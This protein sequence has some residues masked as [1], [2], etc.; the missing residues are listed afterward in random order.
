MLCA[1]S[2]P[3]QPP[4]LAV[5][6]FTNGSPLR[7]DRLPARSREAGDT[8]RYE[9][10]EENHLGSD[11]KAKASSV[12]L[13]AEEE[14]ELRSSEEPLKYT[15][16][17]VVH[18]IDGAV[19]DGQLKDEQPA[20]APGA[21][22]AAKTAVKETGT[23]S[24]QHTNEHMLELQTTMEGWTNSYIAWKKLVSRHG[25]KPRDSENELKDK[26]ATKMLEDA[27]GCIQEFCDE[28]FKNTDEGKRLGNLAEKEAKAG[29]KEASDKKHFA[30]IKAQQVSE[31]KERKVNGR[32]LNFTDGSRGKEMTQKEGLLQSRGLEFVQT[33]EE[34]ILGVHRAMAMTTTGQLIQEPK[35]SD[36][37]LTMGGGKEG[38]ADKKCRKA[39]EKETNWKILAREGKELR[40]KVNLRVTYWAVLPSNIF[41][42]PLTKHP[43]RSRHCKFRLM[44]VLN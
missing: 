32:H 39:Q 43:S 12:P 41:R 23:A 11:N 14:V 21:T 24:G 27:M 17:N 16:E 31:E 7:P 33:H 38:Y 15:I 26:A 34:A 36:K 35:G 19:Q 30:H 9:I 42:I 4:T 44:L 13:I 40:M 6:H 25:H 10:E 1:Q 5:P 28:D 8:R 18:D 37:H 22:A 20:G 3:Q 29:A 2:Q